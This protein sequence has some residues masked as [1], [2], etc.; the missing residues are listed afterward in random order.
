MAKDSPANPPLLDYL[1]ED[2]YVGHKISSSG[3]SK[4]AKECIKERK[5]RAKAT[6]KSLDPKI[7][8]GGTHSRG[9]ADKKGKRSSA[10][11]VGP[12]N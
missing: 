9:S 1:Q 6:L 2:E 10:Q 4:S 8:N 11:T 12:P 3:P 5:S 7:R